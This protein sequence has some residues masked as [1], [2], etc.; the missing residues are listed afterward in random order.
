MENW[1][2]PCQLVISCKDILN[3]HSYSRGEKEFHGVVAT[4]K[5]A[6]THG[7][8]IV[9]VTVIVIAMGDED[10]GDEARIY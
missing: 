8:S 1:E 4:W 2:S 10:E 6:L 5:G 7:V 3:M 9:L